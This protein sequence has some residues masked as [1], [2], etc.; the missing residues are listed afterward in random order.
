VLRSRLG[1]DHRWRG[2]VGLEFAQALRRFGS[3]TVIQRGKQL[4]DRED[5]DIAAAVEELMRDEGIDVLLNANI[6]EV[7]G[8]S[9]ANVAVRLQA[10]GSQR[11]LEGSDILVATG[12]TPNTNGIGLDKTG[13]ELDAR[14]YIQVNERLQTTAADVWAMGECRQPA[15]HT[16]GGERLSGRAQQSGWRKPHYARPPHPLLLVHRCRAAHVGLTE[17]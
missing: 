3:R 1:H 11:T 12:R 15:I 5:P 2:Y 16:R 9:G 14:G 13:I 6:A 4:L 10:G 17:S 7:S 8:R